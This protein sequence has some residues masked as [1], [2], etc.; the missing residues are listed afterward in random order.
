MQF[1]TNNYKR[2]NGHNTW[3]HTSNLHTTLVDNSNIPTAYLTI[4]IITLY[5]QLVLIMDQCLGVLQ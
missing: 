4:S 5:N 2:A 3:H 1:I